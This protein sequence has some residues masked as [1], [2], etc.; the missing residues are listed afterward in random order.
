MEELRLLRSD[1]DRGAD[2]HQRPDFVDLSIRHRDAAVGPVAPEMGARQPTET[3][4]H[5]MY[6]DI[7]TRRHATAARA[8]AI[9]GIGIR[10]AQREMKAAAG[11]LEIDRV[12]TFGG[13]PVAILLLVSAGCPAERDVVGREHAA[14]AQQRHPARRLV[15]DD[16]GCA[17]AGRRKSRCTSAELQE[18]PADRR[19]RTRGDQRDEAER[20]PAPPHDRHSPLSGRVSSASMAPS[21]LILSSST[22]ATA[23]AT[24][25]STPLASAMSVSTAAVNAP[26]ASLSPAAPGRAPRPSAT[27]SEKLRDCG[28]EQVRIRSP[29]PD[30]PVSVSPRAPYA[31][32]NRISSA[33]PRVVSAAAALAPRPRPVTMPAAIASTFLAAPPISTPRTSVA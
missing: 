3:V 33:K 12:G 21:T 7:A 15:D 2:I 28:L 10:D 26:S 29:R 11:I 30:R 17:G 22:A 13:S 20:D 32:P 31:S 8:V 1:L 16:R 9:C 27:P 5:P 4:R 23:A 18:I 6:H 24:G 25:M 19:Q 14:I